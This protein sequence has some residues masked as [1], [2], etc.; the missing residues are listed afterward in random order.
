VT[1]QFGGDLLFRGRSHAKG[2][3]SFPHAPMR[4]TNDWVRF[5]FRLGSLTT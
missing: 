1:S 5:A 2:L 4:H 3:L